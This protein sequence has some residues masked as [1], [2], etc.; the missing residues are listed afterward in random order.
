[1]DST[2]W[3]KISDLDHGWTD[4]I[5]HQKTGLSI[6]CLAMYVNFNLPDEMWSICPAFASDSEGTVISYNL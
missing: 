1:M 6:C 2:H 5:D 3:W 4:N